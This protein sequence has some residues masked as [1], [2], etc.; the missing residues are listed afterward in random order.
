[1]NYLKTH[2]PEIAQR[3]RATETADLSALT[4]FEIEVTARKYMM[5]GV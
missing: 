5:A 3:V 1:M 2:H 4:E